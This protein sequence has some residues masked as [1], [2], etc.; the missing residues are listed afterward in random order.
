MPGLWGLSNQSW[1]RNS[2]AGFFD[3]LG[4]RGR[5]LAIVILPECILSFGKDA[6]NR[7]PDASCA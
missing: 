6:P 2:R 7:L 5:L 4:L 3:A 1:E